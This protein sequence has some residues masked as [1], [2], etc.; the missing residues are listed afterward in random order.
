[1]PSE[2]VPLSEKDLKIAFKNCTANWTI[3]RQDIGREL[4]VIPTGRD[5]VSK[6][7]LKTFGQRRVSVKEIAK[8]I[9]S[10]TPHSDLSPKEL[11]I[12]IYHGFKI[13]TAIHK[14][15]ERKG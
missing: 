4:C 15:L 6:L 13:A 7:F 14:E 1:M 10:M 11:D 2:L 5:E 8:S 12:I 3:T 9:N